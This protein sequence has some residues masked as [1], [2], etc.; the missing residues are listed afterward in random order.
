MGGGSMQIAYELEPNSEKE[1]NSA[2][3][4]NLGCKK[5]DIDHTY[6]VFVTTF[7]GFGANAAR[8][9]YTSLTIILLILGDI[10][11]AYHIF[12]EL[13]SLL[14][15][16]LAH[17]FFHTYLC[18]WSSIAYFLSPF[19]LDWFFRK[20]SMERCYF[21][22]SS[23]TNRCMDSSHSCLIVDK[24][25]SPIVKYGRPCSDMRGYSSTINLNSKTPR[26]CQ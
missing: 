12:I 15:S 11:C 25:D 17:P 2:L 9:R 10:H 24:S 4:F 5:D 6:K 19:S 14:F 8:T 16:S 13:S 26:H 23:I 1:I 20:L 18:F 7:L 21:P 3:T 22:K